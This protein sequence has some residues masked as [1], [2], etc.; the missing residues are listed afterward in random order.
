VEEGTV[1]DFWTLITV[2]VIIVPIEL[3][4]AAWVYKILK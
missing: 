3:I 1:I 2:A 4:V